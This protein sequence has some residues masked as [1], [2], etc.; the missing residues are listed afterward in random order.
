MLTTTAS[1]GGC[2]GP[3]NLNSRPSPKSSS[4]SCPNWNKLI[5]IPTSATKRPNGEAFN[6]RV[7]IESCFFCSIRPPATRVGE[8]Q[9]AHI[10][11]TDFLCQERCGAKHTFT[12]KP[13]IRRRHID[14]RDV[15]LI[16]IE[17]GVAHGD[18]FGQKV[19]ARFGTSA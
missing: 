7:I 5:T 6:K 10:S 2:L 1:P 14:G 12:L 8:K 9:T 16:L 18:A 11:T 19:A 3:R 17:V 4:A 13:A 15:L